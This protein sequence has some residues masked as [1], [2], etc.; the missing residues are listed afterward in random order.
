M[1]SALFCSML[2]IMR[3]MR[4]A[5]SLFVASTGLSSPKK[6]MSARRMLKGSPLS[7]MMIMNF[8]QG[9]C[10]QMTVISPAWVFAAFSTVLMSASRSAASTSFILSSLKPSCRSTDARNSRNSGTEDISAG[11]VTSATKEG[12]LLSAA[13]LAG[14]VVSVHSVFSHL[15]SPPKRAGLD[16]PFMTY[17]SGP[18]NLQSLTFLG[19]KPA[20][21][22]Y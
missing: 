7:R 19:R 3:L 6:T 11:S 14:A 9:S 18:G 1:S 2:S 21:L 13:V 10:L 5:E 22:P 8:P 4:R 20:D 17:P 16:G 12:T 15:F